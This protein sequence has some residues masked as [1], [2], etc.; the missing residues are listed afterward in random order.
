MDKIDK[1]NRELDLLEI[2][3]DEMVSKLQSTEERAARHSLA[4]RIKEKK[5]SANKL[6]NVIFLAIANKD[7]KN[8]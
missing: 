2:T 5:A 6:R 3:I 1:L 4:H 7:V 8:C